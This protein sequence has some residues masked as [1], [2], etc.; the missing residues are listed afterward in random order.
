MAVPSDDC[1]GSKTVKMWRISDIVDDVCIS[2]CHLVLALPLV[3]L[4]YRR[5]GRFQ[6]WIKV[7]ESAVPLDDAPGSAG[8]ALTSRP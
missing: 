1:G 8:M 2:W 7:I 4:Q 6:R 3:R 5:H